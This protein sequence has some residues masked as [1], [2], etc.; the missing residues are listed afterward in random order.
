MTFPTVFKP[1]M[2]AELQ[3]LN[4]YLEKAAES[5][6]PAHLERIE[7]MLPYANTRSERPRD[8]YYERHYYRYLSHP[9]DKNCIVCH[10][11]VPAAEWSQ[12]IG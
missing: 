1:K 10:K 12:N 7:E 2:D 5:D 4:S 6:I 11:S 9:K 8:C 3:L